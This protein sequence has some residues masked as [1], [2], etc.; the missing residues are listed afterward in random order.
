MIAYR[1]SPMVLTALP[2]ASRSHG[3]GIEQRPLTSRVTASLREWLHKHE[4]VLASD[5]TMNFD[6]VRRYS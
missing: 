2:P 1:L 4:L 5:R 3:S 6:G